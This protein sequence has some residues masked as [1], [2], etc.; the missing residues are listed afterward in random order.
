MTDRRLLRARLGAQLLS[1][2][3]PPDPLAATQRLLAIQAQDPRGFRLAIRARTGA[4]TLEPLAD[5]LA[6]RRLIVSWCNRGT[7]HLVA[8]EDFWWL[9]GLTTPP[10]RAGSARRLG[11]EG[12]SPAMAERA[13]GRLDRWLGEDGPLTRRAL[14]DRLGRSG[15]RTEGQALIHI[16]F[17]A[18]LDGVLVRGPLDGAEQAYVRTEDWIGRAPRIDRDRSLAE[19]ARRYV[20]GHGPANARDLARW[21]GLPLRDARAGLAAIASELVP[22]GELVALRGAPPPPPLPPPILLGSFEPLLLGWNDR[23]L[24]TGEFSKALVS[25]GIFRPFALVRGRAGALW[26]LDRG[27]VEIEPLI[28]LT[29][30]ELAALR[31]DGERIRVYLGGR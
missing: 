29:P 19:L 15:V 14:R 8:A 5:D 23:S 26:R 22:D 17:R 4:E 10:L 21:A 18:A 6:Q 11:Q 28:V 9:H 30:G 2:A 27:G 13:V 25:G 3:R 16:L 24:V 12:V 31:R 20:A 7:L 1:G